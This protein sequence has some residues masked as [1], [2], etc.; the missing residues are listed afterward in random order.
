MV[1]GR[2]REKERL[3]I[4]GRGDAKESPALRFGERDRSP[5]ASGQRHEEVAAALKEKVP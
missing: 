1:R 2:W 3:S 5:P 4:N